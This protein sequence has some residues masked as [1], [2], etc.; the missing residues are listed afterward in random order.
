MGEIADDLIDDYINGVDRFETTKYY[1]VWKGHNPGIYLT[2]EECSQQVLRFAG[3]QYKSFNCDYQKAEQLLSKGPKE[4]KKI[5]KEKV[6][7]KE[8]IKNSWAVD[9]ACSGNPGPVEYKGVDVATGKVI[10]NE[11]PFQGGS[12]NIGEF[13]AIVHALA[14]MKKLSIRLPIYSDSQ[15]AIAWVKNKKINTSI[16][17]THSNK[18]LFNIIGRAELWLSKNNYTV[19]IY[20]WNTREWKEIPADFG[21]K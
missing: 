8:F 2:W 21:R 5:Q 20:K 17:E 15:T 4:F 14:L 16:V 3:A 11:G 10:F 12:N 18:T 1:I 6:S 7:S 19:P 13:L 9:A